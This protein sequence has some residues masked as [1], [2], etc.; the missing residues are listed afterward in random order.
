[1]KS[2][3][4]DALGG[5]KGIDFT[6]LAAGPVCTMLMGDMGAD[7]VKIESP[8]GDMARHL[9]PPWAN[10]ESVMFISMNRNKRSL[11]LDLKQPEGMRVFQR[12]VAGADAVLWH[13]DTD[14][15]IGVASGV[16]FY[17]CTIE[18]SDREGTFDQTMKMIVLR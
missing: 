8:Q 11:T 5:I 4:T 2:L 1:M 9:G 18:R 7:V 12:L 3:L 15:G 6:Q 14:A 13:G 17:R 16:Y 10:S